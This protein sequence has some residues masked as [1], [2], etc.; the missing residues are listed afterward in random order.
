MPSQIRPTLVLLAFMTILTGVAYPLAIT[1]LGQALFPIQANGSLV[2]RDGVAVGSEHVGQTFSR[3][4]YFHGRPSAAGGGYDAANS[5]GTNL[6][7]TNR[8]L[9]EAVAE[10]ARAIA[11]TTDSDRIPIDLVTAS[12]SGLDPDISP[13]SAYLQVSRV[14]KA[15]GLSPREIREVVE[16]NVEQPLFG[17]FGKRTVNVLWLN[18]ALDGRSPA[19]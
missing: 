5:G 16:A 7:P 18:L 8:T 15:R 10:R 14:A 17:I 12:G 4:E 6:G 1:G 3:P 9:V 11:A 2:V 19:Q 13:E